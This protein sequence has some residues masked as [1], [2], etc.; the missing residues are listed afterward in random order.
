MLLSYFIGKMYFISTSLID[1]LTYVWGRKNSTARMQA[2]ASLNLPKGIVL[3]VLLFHC[4]VIL[5]IM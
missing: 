1:L 5:Y 4:G 2:L 3:I